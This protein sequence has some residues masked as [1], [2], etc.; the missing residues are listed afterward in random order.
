MIQACAAFASRDHRALKRRRAALML[1]GGLL[2]LIVADPAVGQ[3]VDALPSGGNVVAGTVTIGSP[4]PAARLD[5]NQTSNRAVIE[6]NSFDIGQNAEVTF[7]QPNATAIVLNRVV[8]GTAPSLIA[9]K[10]TA[11][12]VVAVLNSNGA[13]FAGTADVNVGGL[14]ASTGQIDS[15]TFMTG[16]NLLGVGN[17]Q[18]GEIVVSAGASITVA[19]AGLAAFLAPSVRNSGTITATAGRLQLGAGT[20]FTLDLASDGLLQI[21]VGANSPLVQNLGGV[22]ASGGQIQLSARQASALLDQTIRTGVLPV[23]SVRLD[24]NTIVLDATGSDVQL[25][26]DIAGRGDLVLNGS[27]IHGSGDVNVDGNLTLNVNAGGTVADTLATGDNWINDAL[28]VIGAQVHATTVNLGAGLYR[29]GVSITGSNVTLDGQNAAQVGWVSG[30]ENAID[31]RGDH[32]TVKNLE[33]FGPATS[34]YTGFNWGSTNSRGVFVHNGAD[35][36]TVGNNN[37]H[38]IRTGVIVDGRNLRAVVAGNRIDN[39]KSAIS[40]QYTD[41]SNVTLAGNFEGSVGNEWGINVHLNGI[42]QP[43]GV[44]IDPSTASVG[45]LPVGLLGTASLAEQQRLLSLREGNNG[46]SVQ[47]IAYSAANR[48]RAYV[49]TTGGGSNVQG[50]QLTPFSSIQN[51]INAVVTGGTV[52]VANGTYNIGSTPIVMRRGLN[53]VG[54]SQAG[55]IIDGRGVGAG[56]GTMQVQADNVS[57]SNFTLYGA[58]SGANNYGI[59]VQPNSSGG[60]YSPDQRLYNFTIVDVTVR[61]STRAELD[62]NGVIGATISNFTADGRRVSNNAETAGA[63]IQITDSADVTLTGVHTL[64]NTW[65]SVALYQA[66]KPNAYN[67]QTTNINIDASQNTFEE[68]IGVFGQLE[69]TLHGFGQLN[70]TGF[71]YAVRNTD[72]RP[73][74]LDHQFIFYRTSLADAVTFAKT[75]GTA[76]ASSIE[77]YDGTALT[78]VFTVADGLSINSAIRDA[79]TGG[80]INVGAGIYTESVTLNKGLS[81]S[82]AGMNAT[83]I[84]GGM[85]IS[86]TLVDLLLS[87]F[88]ISGT[89]NGTSVIGNGGV[90]TGLTVDAVRI[91]GQNV[92][93]RHG[94]I[95]G[96]IGGAIAITGS[97]FLNIRGWAAFDTRSGAGGN[98]GSQ[99]DAGVFSNNL[100]D[101]TT[102]HIAF[103]QQIG[104]ATLPDIVFSGNTVRSVGNAT[105]SFGAV[106]K[107]FNADQVDFTGNTVSGI[108]TSG[109]NPSGEIAYGA[110]LMTRGTAVLNVTGN[111]FTGNNQV[112]AVEPGRA[113]PGVTNFSGNTFTNNAYSIYLPGNLSGA[114][115]IGFGAANNF[116]A[117][118]DTLRHI[119]WRSASGLDLTGVS[120]NGA[121]ASNLSL[122]Q[123][124]AVEDLI[125]H[126]VDLDG[127][128]LARISAD[129]LFVTTG[130]GAD[131]AL[132]A[133]ALGGDG[134]TLNLSAGTHA[135][136]GTLFLT[137]TIDVAGQGKG[138]TILDA[139]GHDSYGILVHA[140]DVALSGFSLFGPASSGATTYGIKVESGGGATDRNTGFAI[141]NVAVSGSR[142]N[143]LD[144]SA[145]VGATID[146]VDVTGVIEGAGISITDSANVVVHNS[147]TS[148]NA[149]GGLA[150][151]QANDLAGGG[152]DQQL[153]NVTIEANNALGEANGVYLR[154]FSTLMAPGAISVLGYG[155]TVRNPAHIAGG[156]Q[157]TFFQ[158]TLQ[159]AYDYAVSLASPGASIVQGWTGSANDRN[160]HVG[161]GTLAGGGQMA[162]S[163]Q[164]AFGGSANGDIINIASGTYAESAT[165]AGT[166][167]LNFGSVV[168]N[169]LTLSAPVSLGGN[170]TLAT[171]NLAASGALTLTGT[172]SI[173]APNGDISLGSVSGAHALALAG[174][175]LTLGAASLASLSASGTSI[176]TAGVTTTGAQSYTGP[177]TLSGSYGASSLTVN[178]ATT[179]GGSTTIATSGTLSLGTI[180]G[181]QA[182]AISGGSVTLGGASIASFSA[183]GSSIATAGVTTTGAQSYTGPLTLAGSYAASTFTVDGTT[184]LADDTTVTTTGAAAVGALDGPHAFVL[185]AGSAMLGFVG[186]VARLGA[187]SIAADEVVL[188]GG[189]YRAAAFDLAGGGNATVRLTQAETIFDTVSSRGAITFGS[190]LIGTESGQQNISFVTGTGVAGD[191]NIALGNAGTDAVRLGDLSVTGG[192]FAAATVK[193]AG[194][195]TSLLGGSQTFSAE[196]LDAFGDVSA[197]VVGSESGP[198]VAG[199]AVSVTA[200]GSG[201]GSITAGGPVALAYS[202][203]VA[204]AISSQSSVSLTATG[205]VTGSI[206]AIGPVEVS[207]AG[208]VS[209][210]VSTDGSASIASAAGV[211]SNVTAGSGVTLTS[212]LGAVTG[213]VSS[214]G[215]VN[216]SA[217]GPVTGSITAVGPVDVA[218][219]GPVS[220]TVKTNGS[221]AISSATGVSSAVTADGAVKLTSSQGAV[222][223]QIVSGRGVEV[224]AA[225]PVTG[226]IS[227]TGAVGITASGPVS[228]T[229]NAG[230]T[231][232]IS[233]AAGVSS[234]VKAGGAVNVTAVQGAVTGS[235]SSGG[236][237]AV[238]A[239]GPVSATVATPGAASVVSSSGGVSS[240]INAGGPVSVAAPGPVTSSITSGGTVA[241]T[242]ATPINVQVTG[243]TVTV[244][245]P[246]GQ[247]SGNFGRIDTDSGGT[248]VVNDQPVIGGG[249]TDARQI[250]N[251]RF[252][253]P[254]GGRLEAA[255][256][257]A[258]P[259]SLFL[260]LIASH[261]MNT[262]G[263]PAVTV[264]SV[265]R[266]GELLRV[267][268]TAIVIRLDQ[269]SGE[270][271]GQL[272][273]NEASADACSPE[274]NCN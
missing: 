36:A 13:L 21:D 178:G 39:T 106:F 202:N 7:I 110:A 69:S 12:G 112:F 47:N 254:L 84:T 56:L 177:L 78:N 45:G 80:T 245:A 33:I 17:A 91:D 219:S 32:V 213:Q 2:T 104:A 22:F 6:W 38:D 10:L 196:T 113:L 55:V 58:D 115:T 64:G 164:A 44:T 145:V 50:S 215:T 73:D 210:T 107:A 76:S 131:A 88:T 243:G 3:A 168:L 51:G 262:D 258:L 206:A 187:V 62:L 147:T 127:A 240:T 211:S 193:L 79:R 260:E 212:S 248:F 103:R 77:G 185:D 129:K 30:I 100:I 40:V 31:V 241:L 37:I 140:D 93:D 121:L 144:L 217:Q 134:D 25:A 117:G 183:T 137:K 111:T 141:A 72:H 9:G 186:Q 200:G 259:M 54:A 190:H 151:V 228:M 179:L 97:E 120:F 124:F 184:R 247:V 226:S 231:A 269:D 1:S 128:G 229:V 159:N 99:I 170:L 234:T 235:I 43:N 146:G 67:G 15:S 162:L 174:K 8:G 257:I 114:G 20:V 157:Y 57:L 207:A 158:N 176:A 136:T 94:F 66:N 41:G 197:T 70:L 271:A 34:S 71:D 223:G 5:I 63:G 230:T 192:D 92:A 42:L 156:Q 204:R 14:I 169:G 125:T 139:S 27:R 239:Q 24:G 98:D 122:T 142:R 119:V 244:N 143:G 60:A 180:G 90:L 132:R 237:V 101:N 96:Q 29:P 4:S 273:P 253:A 75:V 172:T 109:Y 148:G 161:L 52:I 123:A 225:G 208:L 189:T 272:R 102:G 61:G 83:S 255:G 53:L 85:L 266:L 263:R 11:N 182:L 95:G 155:Y 251:D 175:A 49:T 86:G 252:L 220:A 18:D 268:H 82:G 87:G 166:R 201:S 167:M 205:P 153:D 116:V 261:G 232:N 74:D 163:M 256:D 227:A 224:N 19:D 199:G 23:G 108:G 214:G 221:A 152:S 181:A 274:T 216:V 270:T 198:I 26:S 194:D 126:G 81:L 48:T 233:S 203:D 242:S 165:L 46:M 238:T 173:A 222:S 150:L 236:T 171:G 130:S 154:S 265:D 264:N 138:V 267:G 195:F 249:E 250:I 118:P 89:G 246:G 135:L 68:S 65:G 218:A 149:Q 105:N 160:F 209:A 188:T 16:G 28:G 191:G 133:I 35:D 59:K